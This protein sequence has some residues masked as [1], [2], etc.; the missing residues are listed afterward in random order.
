MET[1]IPPRG[2]EPSTYGYTWDETGEVMQATRVRDSRSF[3]T[4][5][6][7]TPG[8]QSAPWPFQS[9]VTT[10]TTITDAEI[11]ISPVS[12]SPPSPSYY[13]NR[14][15]TITATTTTTTTTTRRSTYQPY[16]PPLSNTND[17][18]HSSSG[19]GEGVGEGEGDLAAAAPA[20]R[21]I[22]PD[23][24]VVNFL[25]SGRGCEPTTTTTTTTRETATAPQGGGAH[26]DPLRGNPVFYFYHNHHHHGDEDEGRRTA[27]TPQRRG[28]DI[29]DPQLLPSSQQ[30]Q[31][32]SRVADFEGFDFGND[33]AFDSLLE[34]VDS[35]EGADGDNLDEQEEEGEGEGEGVGEQ[36]RF[37]ASSGEDGGQDFGGEKGDG[38]GGGGGGGRSSGWWKKC[39]EGIGGGGGGGCGDGWR[40]AVAMI[41]L[42]TFTILIAGFVCL[43]VA[44]TGVSPAEDGR[45]AVFA[46][47]C[48]TA[49]AIDRGL[50]AAINVL[51]VVLVAGANYTFQILSSPTRS[52]VTAAHQG[53]EWLDIGV[54]SFRNLGRI[55]GSRTLLAVVLLATAVSTQML[56]NAVI[57][58]SQTA[59]SLKAV[60]VGESF[61]EGSPFSNGDA[62]TVGGLSRHE[63]LLLQRRAARDELVRLSTPVCIDHFSGAFQEE[64]SAVLV[65][66]NNKPPI[67][68]SSDIRRTTASDIR[69]CLA[70][71][72]SAP[73]C[74]VNLNASLLGTVSLLNSIA[75]VATAAVLFMRPSSF[76]PLAT[77]GDAISSFLEEAD[78]MTQGSCLLSKADVCQGR[79]P[80]TEAKF[81][82]PKNHYWLHSVSFPRWV[83]AFFIWATCVGLAATA[84]A[85]SIPNPDDDDSSAARLSPFGT[86]SPHTL[87]LLPANTPAAAAA[88]VA[89]L[90]QLLLAAL[91]FATN[92][93]LTSY[94]LSHESSLF[95]LKPARPLRVSAAANPAGWQTTSLHLTLPGPVSALL[96]AL[97]TA[98]S[99][100]LSRSIFA[101]SVHLVDVPLLDLASSSSTAPP[102]PN[103]PSETTKRIIVGL[104][105]SGAGLLALLSL[106]AALAAG[107]IALGLRR[108]PPA[109]GGTVSSGGGEEEMVGNP[110]ALPAGSCSAVISA[111]CHPLAR[112]RTTITTSATTSTTTAAREGARELLLWE[113]PVMWGVVRE[114]VGFAPSHCAFTAGRAG[115]VGAGRNYA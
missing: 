14:P 79:W 16:R 32:R 43:V 55:R 13:H 69:Y 58:V 38:A 56:Y 31:H 109:A 86:A 93:L 78:P 113:K 15:S 71:P 84:L 106:L 62:E 8:R 47:S 65:I 104:G 25:T 5:Q 85:I 7:L 82:L 3:S 87:L 97:F 44:I 90:P 96:M 110:M 20:E 45:T 10:T 24:Y 75:L 53:R 72:A 68:E 66:S 6:R 81:W 105:L 30:Q 29:V 34:R 33:D 39:C 77:L 89:S 22:V 1:V 95:A 18:W 107:V 61:L 17:S 114:G 37:L 19:E 63:L 52:E 48:T 12:T 57:F 112:E 83:V 74:E 101:V 59:P 73:T 9:V 41:V 23:S 40:A 54:P 92:A 49:R 70:Q 91:Y 46:G 108:A 67:S 11:P 88:V 27:A 36:R 100:V 35:R 102:P 21:D 103:P 76:R 51:V 98:M 26:V 111:R 80:L 60:V 2:H 99:F 28:V 64:Y 115:V 50:H 42:A 4:Q 94:F